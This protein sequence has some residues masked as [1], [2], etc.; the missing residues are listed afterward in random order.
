MLLKYME[1]KMIG[2]VLAVCRSREKGTIKAPIKYGVLIEGYGLQ[3]DAHAGEW[4]RQISLLGIES[5]NKITRSGI[6]IK[7]GD[8][9]E[10]LTIEGINLVKLSVGTR[11]KV[12]QHILLEITQIGKTCHHDC[13]IKK[14]IGDCVMPKEGVFARVLKGGIVRSGDNIYVVNDAKPHQILIFK[15]T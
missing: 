14:K 2:K 12:G 8:F 9:A 13:E 6:K 7:F 11:L 10:N 15:L 4:H 3:G 5:I 1:K